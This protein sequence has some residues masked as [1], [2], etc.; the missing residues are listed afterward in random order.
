MN[1][2]YSYGIG[3]LP[4]KDKTVIIPEGMKLESYCVYLV[5]VSMNVYN[6]IFRSMLIVGF[7]SENGGP[8]NYSN[9]YS[10]SVSEPIDVYDWEGLHYLK[11]IKLIATSADMR[12]D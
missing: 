10:V 6:P 12:G 5:D 1:N 11:I 3:D 7:I 2:A 9:I 4:P 8:G